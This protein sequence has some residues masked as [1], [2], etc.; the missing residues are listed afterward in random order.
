M[1]CMLM[2]CKLFTRAMPSEF[3]LGRAI[4]LAGRRWRN[5]LDERLQHVDLTQAR[6]HALLE[7]EKAGDGLRQKELASRIGIEPP[8][9]VRQL[10]DLERRG[11]IRREAIAG[12]R[13]VN[14]VHLTEA[15]TPVLA[16]ILKIAQQVRRE[17]TE[18]L[19]EADLATASRV[20][21]H[22]NRR[23]EDL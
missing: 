14:A 1:L 21:E 11:L 15:A 8:T 4:A 13:R 10:D 9:L 18:G 20:I 16:E 12:D 5:R 2:L 3:T 6:W 22:I 19:S 7:L 23:L 17:I